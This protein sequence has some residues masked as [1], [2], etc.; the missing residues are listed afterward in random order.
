MKKNQTL[1]APLS[2]QWTKSSIAKRL[3]GISRWLHVYLSATLLCL[4]LFF[5]V[6]G[7]TLNHA[8]WFDS[9][10]DVSVDTYPLPDEL[11]QLLSAKKTIA[12]EPLTRF[13]QEELGLVDPRS[14]DI[15]LE[16]GELYLDYP[17]PAG[18]AFVSIFLSE[19]TMEL[20]YRTGNLV[21]LLNDLHKG[22]YSGFAWSLLIDI[23]AIVMTVFS[24][25]GL[26]ILLQHKK[27]RSYGLLFALVGTLT[28]VLVYFLFVPHY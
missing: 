11:I 12:V 6:T 16:I 3:F 19:Q 7:F 1:T 13:I 18:Y 8:S 2:W 28:P 15:E 14:I 27:Y 4:L 9:N 17:L 22:R 10:N 21:A 5:C 23:S 24:L 20:E 26:I 25:A